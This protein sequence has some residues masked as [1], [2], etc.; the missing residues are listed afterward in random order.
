MIGGVFAVGLGR[1]PLGRI[2]ECKL[3]FPLLR[4]ILSVTNSEIPLAQIVVIKELCTESFP[5]ARLV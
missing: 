4:K 1:A 3:T 5:L 2:R